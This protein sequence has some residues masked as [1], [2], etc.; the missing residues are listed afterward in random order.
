NHWLQW[1]I[2]P[3][4]D[5]SEIEMATLSF[6]MR[7]MFEPPVDVTVEGYDGWDTANVWAS[8]DGGETWEVIYPA[9]GPEYTFESSYAFGF[10]WGM[11]VGIPGWGG[12]YPD[13]EESVFDLSEYAGNEAV[14]VKIAFCSDPAAC[15]DDAQGDPTWTGIQVD[16]IQVFDGNEEV[17]FFDNADGDN[18]GGELIPFSGLAN[19]LE[20]QWSVIETE[21]AW[22][23]THLMGIEDIGV[24]FTH[25]YQSDIIDLSDVAEESVAR[26][27]VAVKGMWDHPNPTQ[28][29]WTVKIKPEDEDTWYFAEYPYSD[30]PGPDTVYT[31]APDDWQLVTE[32]FDADWDLEPYHDQQIQIRV[33]FTSPLEE[34]NE[35]DNFIYFDDFMVESFGFPH[36]VGAHTPMIPFP[37]TVN[38]VIEGYVSIE[39]FG[40]N[41][42]S[43]TGVWYNPSPHTFSP[44]FNLD[45][46]EVDTRM[47]DVDDDDE[48]DGWMPTEEGTY[49]V[50]ARVVLQGD[51]NGGNNVSTIIPVEVR[52]EGS[53]E[54]GYDTRVPVGATDMFGSGDGTV[55]H[56]M[57]PDNIPEFSVQYL[58]LMW[59]DDFPEESYEVTL[60]FME[61]GD[62]PPVDFA[63]RTITV[64][65]ANAYPNWQ[66][67]N[68][69]NLM[70][71]Q[72]F[73]G[74]FW[75]A[76]EI[77]EESGYPH[78]MTTERGLGVDHHFAEIDGEMI[79]PEFDFMIRVLGFEGEGPTDFTMDIP[80][81]ANYFELVSTYVDPESLTPGFVF[82]SIESLVIA[83]QND[84]SIFIP[85]FIDTILAIDLL[86]GYRVFAT[87]DETWTVEGPYLDTMMEYTLSPNQWNWISYPFNVP[88]N[89]ET[90]LESIA[91]DIVILQA[92]DGRFWIPNFVNTVDDMIPGEGYMVFLEDGVTFQYN[93]PAQRA[94]GST[95]PKQEL[96]FAPHAPQPTGLPYAVLVELD[97]SFE[98]TSPA[99]VELYDGNI[100]VG[101]SIVQENSMVPLIAWEGSPEH[102]LK[103][104]VQGNSIRVQVLDQSGDLIPIEQPVTT[105]KFGSEPYGSLTLSTQNTHSIPTS[106]SMEDAYPNPFNPTVTIPFAIPQDG[107]VEFTVFD[108]LGRVVLEESDRF[109]AGQH[110]RTF[111]LASNYS[112]SGVYFLQLRFEQQVLRQKVLLLK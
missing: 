7:M 71:Y 25:F 4:L 108:L 77:T 10:E 27:N 46:G 110:R 73:T 19:L 35:G 47:L 36:D 94:A 41:P 95:T 42:E 83:Y 2:T 32:A 6:Q 44:R 102:D 13:W 66:Q 56:F 99:I 86:Q 97:E 18:I 30:T 85:P 9:E 23:G 101:A 22:S 107:M 61:G 82:G 70:E 34:F 96:A 90:A 24:G 29:F 87:A 49:E 50:R 39:N 28:V 65:E 51:D 64:T 20:N 3:V 54:L 45:V 57:I 16:D 84:G 79:D 111:D 98:N 52:E 48:I 92:D 89:V 59:D 17:L 67:I 62:E 91:D 63:T 75:I 21:D 26:L 38:Y 1:L 69:S 81:Q 93:Q 14:R 8:P 74:D 33:E 68:I 104:F 31:S 106:F 12:L 43:F 112:V 55:T 103:G 40:A 78:L 80:I 76:V 58:R 53:Y 72:Q 5:F 109:E 100:L 60:H 15:T 88:L 105:S 37:N 11:G